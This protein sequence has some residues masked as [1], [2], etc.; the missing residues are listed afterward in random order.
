LEQILAM[1]GGRNWINGMGAAMLMKGRGDCCCG[2]DFS[3][4]AVGSHWMRDRFGTQAGR[5]LSWDVMGSVLVRSHHP[6][7]E[8]RYCPLWVPIDW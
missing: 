5:D 3:L 4:T 8:L 2:D 7:S 6:G 1:N